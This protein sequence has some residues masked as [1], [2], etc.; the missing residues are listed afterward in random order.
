[1]AGQQYIGTGRLGD[2]QDVSYTG[3][4]GNST[5]APS[6]VIKVRVIV[7]TAAYVKIGKDAVAVSPGTYMA[8]GAGE[9]FSITPG[10]RVSAIQVASG[11][12]L[13]VTWLV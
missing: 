9:S 2:A 5:A 1:M 10:E 13:N 8:A 4:A 3:T 6:G 11:G 12:T 7:T